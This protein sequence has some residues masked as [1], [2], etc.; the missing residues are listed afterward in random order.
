[1]LLHTM[2]FYAWPFSLHRDG[3]ITKR[4]MVTIAWKKICVSYDEGD[5]NLI[6]LICLN[7]ATNMN[8]C[9]DTLHS[10]KQ[11]A[12]ILRSRPLRGVN[13]IN[14]HIFSSLWST[15]KHELPV[16][17]DNSTWLIGNGKHINFWH[18]D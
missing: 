5:L 7:E 9:W 11:W 3:H 4:K 6:S 13:W 14:H 2:S 15:I 18:D 8:L 10:N 17:K 16:I 1:M 12:V